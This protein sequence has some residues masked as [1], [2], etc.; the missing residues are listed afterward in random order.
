MIGLRDVRLGSE[1]A[2]ASSGSS[3]DFCS[4]FDN[5]DRRLDGKFTNCTI[6]RSRLTVKRIDCQL[7][8]LLFFIDL[9]HTKKP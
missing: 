7:Y 4:L 9:E 5:C 2:E 1:S 8:A 3:N 6:S